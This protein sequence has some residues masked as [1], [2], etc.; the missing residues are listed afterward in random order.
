[1][2][3]SV[4]PVVLGSRRQL[5]CT[6]AA[7]GL[8]QALGRVRGFPGSVLQRSS[9]FQCPTSAPAP[10]P[11]PLCSTAYNALS[12]NRG[13]HRAP[14]PLPQGWDKSAEGQ[15]SRHRS[16]REGLGSLPTWVPSGCVPWGEPR[17]DGQEGVLR[18][19][20]APAWSCSCP[21]QRRH[22][23][24]EGHQVGVTG[25]APHLRRQHTAPHQV[26]AEAVHLLLPRPAPKASGKASSGLCLFLEL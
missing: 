19:P 24:E 16:G 13:E 23:P 2:P 1:M 15:C 17:T 18:W 8:C 11:G 7:L 4:G 25:P 22:S 12:P 5:A 26:R 20:K 6:E 21:A 3:P 14:R 10:Q 9:F